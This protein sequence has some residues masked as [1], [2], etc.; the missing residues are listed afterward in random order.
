MRAQW[1]RKQDSVRNLV[2]EQKINRKKSKHVSSRLAKFQ[3]K[4]FKNV[5]ALGFCVNSTFAISRTEVLLD[6][7]AH[8]SSYK[9][10]IRQ[11]CVVYAYLSYKIGPIKKYYI[12]G[13]L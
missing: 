10:V 5:K 2:C 11:L 12:L 3:R 1:A 7:N 4:N 8:F 6:L 9:A 13:I